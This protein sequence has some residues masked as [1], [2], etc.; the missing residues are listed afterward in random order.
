MNSHLD[1]DTQVQSIMSDQTGD[2]SVGDLNYLE[3][4]VTSALQDVTALKIPTPAVAYQKS[5]VADLLY[6]KNLIPLYNLA[7]T[8]PVRA[9][10]VFQVEDA[11]FDSV[12]TNFLNQAQS[13][14]NETLSLQ[15]TQPSPQG[16]LLS[17]LN[18]TFGIQ[19][20]HA[21]LIVSDPILETPYTTVQIPAVV[22]QN[23]ALDSIQLPEQNA[24]LQLNLTAHAQQVGTSASLFSLISSIHVQNMGQ[25]L[26]AL[27]KN[28]LLQILRNTLIAIIQREVVAWINGS[29]APR[30]IT[31][32][33]TQLVDAAQT[34]ALNSINTLFDP[35]GCTFPA[36][37]GQE[38][39]TLN[40]FY[41]P[42]SNACANQ[43]AAALGSNSFQQFYNNFKNGG[44]IAFGAST[45][46]SGNP[47][48]N[49]FF[50]AQTVQFAYQLNKEQAN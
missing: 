1:S 30:F 18:G 37:I 6:E 26:E 35:N 23:S 27:L 12:E 8:D 20:A 19:Q 14:T 40:A 47:Y 29:G 50:N 22:Q 11:R 24:N 17:L 15:Q 28:T 38:K 5:L 21:Q 41:K 34:S 2:T 3:S 7:Q 4:Q 13:L 9:T 48:G 16:M 25:R 45:L 49:L 46:P 44:F 31:N 10:I 39:I 42:G 43:F 32:W 36:F 33:G